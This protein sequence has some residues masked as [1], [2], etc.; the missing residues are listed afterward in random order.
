M[1]AA[2]H[3][4]R[5]TSIDVALVVVYL[6]GITGLGL[7][8]SRG[9][10]TS[11]DFFLGGKSIP[12]WAAGMSLVVSDIGAK[13]MVGLSG[14]A[15]RYGVVMMN[16]DFVGCTLPLLLAAF[17]FMPFFWRS[18][19]TTIPEYLGRRYNVAV[20]TFFAVVWSLF[21]VGTIATILVSAAAMFEGLLGWSFWVS[22][23]VTSV[24]VGLYTTSGGLRAVV[25]TDVVSCVVLIVGAALI[26]VL[27]LREVGGVAELVERVNALPWTDEHFDL[28]PSATHSAYPWPAVVLGLGLVLG[29]AY[30]VGNQAIVQR[31]LGTR[32][33]EDA[34]A[35][36][37]LCAAIKLVFPVLLVLPGLIA[38][39]L[40]ADELG[41]PAPGW[42]ANQV[43]PLMVKRLVPPGALGVLLGAF[44]AG[45]MAN[46]DSYINSASTLLVTDLY[47]PFVKPD[48]SDAD[49]LRLG[50]YLVV[51]LLA[52]GAILSFEVKSRFGSVFEAF[53]TFLSFFQGALFALLL[54]GML[55]RRATAMGGVAG[56]IAGVSTA[57]LLNARGQLYL[58][59][60]FWSFAAASVVLV[61]VSALTSP[62]SEDELRGLVCWVPRA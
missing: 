2:V 10:R 60:A 27:G 5:L 52:L 21:M 44:V 12:W 29:P 19:V 55:T 54:F 50:R 7:W 36:Y 51:G 18:D 1:R 22:V 15:Y 61:L 20:R 14:D 24:L 8:V 39:A 45:I 32:S 28:L 26:C 31:T 59:T 46:L 11:R 42:D 4:V 47:R 9:V 16:F 3:T 38:L 56:M 33:E 57:A 49:C 53:Q 6:L 34:R 62:K 43:L 40:F 23:G 37:V 17:L 58:W 30:W 13:D 48:A 35:S 25:A 41:A